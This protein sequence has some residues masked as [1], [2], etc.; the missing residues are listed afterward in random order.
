M[1]L[2]AKKQLGQHFLTDQGIIADIIALIRSECAENVPMI[3]VG[4]GQG[5]LTQEL[6]D[7]FGQFKAIEF[8]RDMVAILNEQLPKLDLI[9][10]DFL[11][12]PID[13]IFNKPFNIVGNFPYNISTEI[14]FKILENVE[15]VTTMVGM[16]QKEV[17]DRICAGPKGRVN[18]IISV[19]TQAHY[20]AEKMFDI[21]PHAFSP[22]PRVQSA[23]IVLRRKENYHI[24]CD[25]KL[26]SKVIKGAYGQR[27]KK[28]R[29]TLKSILPDTDHPLLQKRPEELSVEEFVIIAKLA[30]N[31]KV[32]I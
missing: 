15:H 9:Q 28:M 25:M 30:E 16:F 8:D 17:A 13:E 10:D 5:V 21:P 2:K 24:D 26:F 32:D 27:R 7:M 29:N 20:H 14:V 3:E 1:N 4:P 31:K 22:P 11:K 12:V 6:I 18:G 23:M 19:R